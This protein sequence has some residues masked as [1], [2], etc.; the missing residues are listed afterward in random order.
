MRYGPAMATDHRFAL[1]TAVLAAVFAS[2]AAPAPAQQRPQPAAPAA[3][4]AAAVPRLLGTFDGW[5]AFEAEPNN[6][7][8][9]YV[10][11]A[12]LR[13]E[14]R[15]A[16]AQRGEISLVIA[17]HRNPVRNDEFTMNLGSPARD[18]GEI[19]I[20]RTKVPLS[21][22]AQA[23]SSSLW[24]R[25]ADGDRQIVGALRTAPATGTAIVRGT[26]ARGTETADTFA[27]AGF[28]RALAEIDR[29][30]GVRRQ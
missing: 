15:P 6:A 7:K 27:L 23:N 30:C 16:N 1:R 8:I 13:S 21:T 11:A 24:S 2:F 18:S 4:P 3:Q 28:Q 12:P 17:H 22:L 5:R 19:E 26:S 29:A 10:M 20:G 14:S 25:P 9:C